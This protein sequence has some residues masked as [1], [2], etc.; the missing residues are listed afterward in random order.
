MRDHFFEKEVGGE[1]YKHR[2]TLFVCTTTDAGKRLTIYQRAG[3]HPTSEIA[4]EVDDNDLTKCRGIAGRI[5]FHTITLMECHDPAW[6]TD[7]D[8]VAKERYAECQ[9]ISL[10]EAERLKVKSTAFCGTIVVVNGEKW[11]VLLIDSQKQ[12]RFDAK[13]HRTRNEKR[14][15]RYATLLSQVLAEVPT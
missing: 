12:W 11:G 8:P 14:I 9:G 15:E 6:P 3:V 4:W 5:W 13:P 7:D 2:V 1:R 10:A